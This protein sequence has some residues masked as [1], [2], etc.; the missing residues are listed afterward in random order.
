MSLE[1]ATTRQYLNYICNV[2]ESR[3]LLVS[4]SYLSMQYLNLIVVV[5]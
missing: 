4:Q 2:N 5:N 1:Y 3:E